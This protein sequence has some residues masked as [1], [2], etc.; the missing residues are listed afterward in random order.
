MIGDVKALQQAWLEAE[1]AADRARTAVNSAP[2]SDRERARAAHAQ[3]EASASAAFD[4]LWTAKSG[5]STSQR[6]S[7]AA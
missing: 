1:A 2:M 7:A 6:E 5:S 3:A 4:R